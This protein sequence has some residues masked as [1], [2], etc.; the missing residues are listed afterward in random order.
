M[1][2]F[3]RKDSQV[4][5]LPTPPRQASTHR[6]HN[7]PGTTGAVRPDR[8]YGSAPLVHRNVAALIRTEID[9]TGTRDLLLAVGKHFHPLR[10][11]TGGSRDRKQYR[12]HGD[13]EPHRLIDEPGV[14]I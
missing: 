14:K 1:W 4:G 12:E 11:P 6:G 2:L 9:L 13:R 8:A 7:R 10:D 3:W 5:G